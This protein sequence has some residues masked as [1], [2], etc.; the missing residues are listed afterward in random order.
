MQ[1]GGVRMDPAGGAG[2]AGG[3]GAGAGG[4][5]A[6]AMEVLLWYKYARLADPPG[7]A[8]AQRALAARLGLLGR[9][10][11]AAEGFNGTLSGPPDAV[12]AYVRAVRADARMAD[13]DFKFS[14]AAG[15]HPFPDLVVKEVAE[16]VSSGGKFSQLQVPQEQYA[17]AG[18]AGALVG[19]H[20]A[21]QDFHA[22]LQ[23]FY[24]DREAAA[25]KRRR[26][27]GVAAAGEARPGPLEEEEEPGALPPE[28][29]VLLDVRNKKEYEVGRFRGAVD[30]KADTFSEIARWLEKHTEDLR[31]RPIMMY[32]TGGIRCE[33]ASAFLRSQG[34]GFEDVTQLKG[35][36]HRYLEAFEDGGHF[37]GKNF[38]FDRR[39]VQP[40]PPLVG[41]GSSG[42]GA[43]QVVGRCVE[44]QAAWETIDWKRV[45][46]VC[47][48]LVMV[49]DACFAAR[50]G[51]SHCHK[52]RHL[53]DLYFQKLE[54]FSPEE[55]R[56][57][58]AELGKLEASLRGTKFLR[59]KRATL[60]KQVAKVEAHLAAR[61]GA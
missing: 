50:G 46:S 30:M 29:P 16:L 55:L 9:V 5:A 25:V 6:G 31:G 7:E 58:A 22:A 56:R 59:K 34:E 2:A 28:G 51:E 61:A 40:T 23:A 43:G 35:G 37:G 24:D 44:C 3:G 39:L 21:P 12:R 57:Q 19:R 4:G 47:R 54:R 36:I 20:L 33:K 42:G 14:P 60:R 15:G 48:G 13:I 52:H 1:S 49:C 10:L 41:G 32:C 26:L 45:C 11:V 38:V 8:A 17:D 18:D 53:R 27:E